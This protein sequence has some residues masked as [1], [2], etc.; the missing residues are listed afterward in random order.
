[1]RAISSLLDQV[2]SSASNGLIVLAVARVASVNAFGAATLLFALAAAA[3]GIGRGAV[4]TP[5]MLAADRGTTELRREAG[6]ATTAALL[7]GLVVS[8]AAV[9]CAHVL[10]VPHMGAA[11]ALAIPLLVIVDV[12]RYTLISASKP[13]LALLWDS[14]WALG[15]AALFVITLFRPDSLNGSTM[16]LMWAIL[17]G[18]SAVGMALSYQLRPRFRGIGAWWRETYGSRLRYGIEAGL[19]QI[20]VLIIISIATALIGASAAASLRGAATI[21]SPLAILLSALPL[22]I[23]PE[24]IRGGVPGSVVWRKLCRIGIP[25]SL[26]VI[27]IAW[28]LVLLPER[29]GQLILGDSWSLA[30]VV[31]PIIAFEYVG[32]IWVSI[33]MSYLRF[34]G[35]SGRLLAAT[36]AYCVISIVLCTAMALLT[37]TA[38]GVAVGLAVSA[39]AM[40]VVT[41]VYVRPTGS[42]FKFRIG[43]K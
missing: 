20:N 25:S 18:V 29:V 19:G 8:G 22:M 11:F 40:A 23:I 6:H 16:V 39:V 43:E 32:L 35:K 9:V 3:M 38:T 12:F 24:A 34:Q 14:V 30:K 26:L 2:M 27:G 17:A 4:G 42:R 7:F 37:H 1:L 15:S 5:L 10:H 21:L 36:G 41:T 13:H 33:A 28:T 31:L